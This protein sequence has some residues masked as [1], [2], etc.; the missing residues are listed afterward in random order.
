MGRKRAGFTLIELL[1]V[2]LIVGILAA[3]AIPV[4]SDYTARTRQAVDDTNTAVLVG[5][6]KEYDLFHFVPWG[7]VYDPATGKASFYNL[8]DPKADMQQLLSPTDLNGHVLGDAGNPPNLYYAYG[9]YLARG[10]PF[11]P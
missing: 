6:I 2:L 1:M 11:G 3:A 9:P 8:T 7:F 4:L 10:G 5:A